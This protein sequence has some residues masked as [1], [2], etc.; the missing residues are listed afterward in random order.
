[1]LDPG[2][3][4][5]SALLGSLSSRPPTSRHGILLADYMA[6]RRE[7]LTLERMA[8]RTSDRSAWRKLASALGTLAA[9]LVVGTRRSRLTEHERN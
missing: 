7:R 6:R 5:N 2:F 3:H 1:M 4:S 9:R 8:A